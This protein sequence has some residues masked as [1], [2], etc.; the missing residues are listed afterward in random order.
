M[1]G[2]GLDDVLIGAFGND[3]SGYDAGK[4]YLILGSSL[5]S[6]TPLGSN[7]EIE[8]SDADY[9]FVGENAWDHASSS[10]SSAGDVNGDG[11][12]DMLVGAPNND[13]AGEHTG[14]AY[15]ILGG[16]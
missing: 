10:V 12:D 2:D 16:F 11:L 13:D 5:G 1:D 7:T 8:P 6:N 9:S 15:V 3:D 14:K 4:V